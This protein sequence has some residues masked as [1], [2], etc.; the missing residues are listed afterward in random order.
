MPRSQLTD[1]GVRNLKPPAAGQVTHWDTA[2]RGFAVRI[3]Q[4]GSRTFIVVHGEDR[5]RRTLGHY[6]NMS[7][8]A[9]RAQAK[10]IFAGIT[11]GF[12]KSGKRSKSQTF[13]DV[14]GL[15]L[16]NVEVRN[17]PRTFRDYK[18][19]LNRHF[20]P[21]LGKRQIGDIEAHEIAKII[22]GILRTPSECAHAFAVIK[23]FFRWAIRRRITKNNPTDGLQGPPK[24][25]ARERVL[26]ESELRT[27]LLQARQSGYPFG[28]V[29]E[30]LALTG[31]RRSEIGAL[32]WQ[33]IDTTNQTITLPSSVTKNKREHKLP[34]DQAVADLLAIIP[35]TGSFLFPGDRDTEL[36]FSGWSNFKAAFD[37]RCKIAPWTLHDLRRTFATNLAALGVRLEVTEKLLNHISGSFSGIVGVYQRHGYQDEMRAAMA[38]WE[39]RLAEITQQHQLSP[40]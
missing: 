15:F 40:V 33:W 24:A 8:S 13:H 39:K 7:L 22:D 36:P 34:Y 27:V 6:P 10:Q 4:G 37:K 18:R 26:T 16:S 2:L 11:L 12:I 25:R 17:K 29:L 19:L 31:Q 38:V 20:L 5:K 21:V 35:R 23:I 1:I 3:S 28:I 9:A 32:K 14:A 30:L